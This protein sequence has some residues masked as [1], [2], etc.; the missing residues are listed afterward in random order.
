[1]KLLIVDDSAELRRELIAQFSD[2]PEISIVGEADTAPI[3]IALIRSM[4]PD[5]V[6]L[7]LLLRSGSGFNV[8]T[9]TLSGPDVPAIIVLSNLADAFF[10]ARC[11]Q[12]HVLRFFDKSKQFQEAVALC[13][14]L[15]SNGTFETA[16]T[17]Q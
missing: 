9:A 1:M 12:P 8:M 5:V 17:E 3:A 6:L 2:T 7:D 4:K 13:R 11:Q 15:A 10:R 14:E 16:A